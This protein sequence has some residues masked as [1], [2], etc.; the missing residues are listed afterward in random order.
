MVYLCVHSL[1]RG[2]SHMALNPCLVL[3]PRCDGIW[4]WGCGPLGGDYVSGNIVTGLASLQGAKVPWDHEQGRRGEQ[5][6]GQRAHR[7]LL[8]NCR[9]HP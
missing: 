1:E 7:K 9:A 8:D 5:T 4:R 2:H 3:N 6:W